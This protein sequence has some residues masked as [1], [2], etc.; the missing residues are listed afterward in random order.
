MISE[1]IFMGFVYPYFLFGLFAIAIPIVIHLFN[2]RR[3][4]KVYFTNVK[5]LKDLKIE[6]RKQNKL[7][8][9]LLLA[10]RCLSIAFLVLLF[11]NPYIKQDENALVKEGSN[12]VLIFVDNSFSME[13]SANK[14]SLLD[15]AKTKAKEIAMQY[16]ENDNFCLLTQDMSGKHKHFVNREEFLNLLSE[17]EITASSLPMSQ[18]IRSS[19]RFIHT[20]TAK[21][22]VC[23]YVSDFQTSRFDSENFEQNK[24]NDIFIPLKAENADNV[25]IDSVWLE[26]SGLK[27]GEAAN[28]FAKIKN[29]SKDSREN[30]AVKLFVNQKQLTSISINLEADEEQTIK[31][32]FTVPQ[33]GVLHSRLSVSDNPV[34]FDDDFY[35]TLLIRDKVKTLAINQN[36]QNKHLLR[37]LKEDES[38][39]FSNMKADNLDFGQFGEQSM[40]ILNELNEISSGLASE[41]SN[42]I[43][44]G[45]SLC[46]IPS[47]DMDLNSYNLFLKSYSAPTYERLLEK[48]A[49]VASIDIESKLFKGVFT[50]VT[51][52]MEKPEAKKYFQFSNSSET[53]AQS[54]MQFADGNDFLVLSPQNKSDI[55][56]F[57]VALQEDWSNIT[58]QSIFVPCLWNMCSMS[59]ILP[60]IY[61]NLGDNSFIDLSAY[62]NLENKEICMVKNKTEDIAFI[63]Q[64][65]KKNKQFGLLSQGQTNTA[66]NYNVWLA[67][68][69][70]GGFSLNYSREES[71]L[72]F[73][74]P[75]D[76]ESKLKENKIENSRVFST[77]EMIETQF[78]KSKVG[79]SFTSLLIILILISIGLEIFLLNRNKTQQ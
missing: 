73:L 20:H 71:M 33:N 17:V 76:L 59:R 67:D 19:H 24:L 9:I 38:I 40:I 12:A 48:S 8:N 2:F 49:K 55:Y 7:R 66:D 56:L 34:C 64:I 50:S 58:N 60:Q 61:Y 16:S 36:E 42:F 43:E 26:N 65:L 35:F 6:S 15:F 28:L 78:Q 5:L 1:R 39:E 13:N 4:K 77:R 46:V 74:S 29:H 51:D 54:I 47:K 37:L 23:F 11:A 52:N 62:I 31:M 27:V 69:L 30:L 68:S 18:I 44:R 63:P 21:N 10:L 14:G 25:F 75:Q 45:G 79:F 32:S 41:L 22:K 3:F 72:E 53:I 70:I 57:A